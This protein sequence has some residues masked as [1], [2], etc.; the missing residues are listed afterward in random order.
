MKKKLMLERAEC[1]LPAQPDSAAMCL[2]SIRPDK[3]DDSQ[4]ALY[5]LLRTAV[6]NFSADGI[7]SD[8]LIRESYDYYYEKSR[9]CLLTDSV[10]LRRYAQSSYYMGVFYFSTDSV[11]K[12]DELARQAVFSAKS[13][14][15]FHTCYLAHT[16][17]SLIHSQTS[18]QE[19]VNQALSALDVYHQI[20]DAVN[21]EVLI[22]GHVAASYLANDQP[23]SA[24][25]YYLKGYDL[26]QS[27]NLRD[28]QNSMCMGLADTYCYMGS[29]WYAL[30]YAKI[31]V[32]TADSTTM[33]SSLLSLAQCYYANDSLTQAK[34][35]LDTLSCDSDD[36]ASRY[37]TF[38]TLSEIALQNRNIDT[39]YA[40][41]DSVYDFMK[42]HFSRE[43]ESFVVEKEKELEVV[44]QEHGVNWMLGFIVS[45]VLVL[46]L[47]AGFVYMRYGGK[48]RLL[49]MRLLG[50]VRADTVETAGEPLN[51]A[52]QHNALIQENAEPAGKSEPLLSVQIDKQVEKLVSYSPR[53]A[54]DEKARKRVE[55][56]W[57]NIEK[58]LGSTHPQF[59]QHLRQHPGLKEKDF[60]LCMLTF[61]KV[62][63]AAI[64]HIFNIGESAVKKRKST[65]K[66]QTFYVE[67]ASVTLEQV[68]A[69]F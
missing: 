60:Q 12:S 61:L 69:K 54:E 18:P 32:E 58:V 17:L 29:F 13:V 46:L 39:L 19:A 68:L 43:R 48:I 37:L 27:H 4:R 31:G 47:V 1:Y 59:V 7:G 40:Y 6:I 41:V 67:D 64:A 34:A 56:A 23:D 50:K 3:L 15:D 5:G 16:L 35:I 24:L 45:A 53:Q 25:V 42:G 30:Y 20:N 51:L 44:Q 33:T 9:E 8:T 55:R 38:R 28:A 57:R 26:A 66:K 36:F 65:L 52:S 14:G 63:N 2:D 62:P 11:E 10:L 21:N 22:M 49:S